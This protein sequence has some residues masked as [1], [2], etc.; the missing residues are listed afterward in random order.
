MGY[1]VWDFVQYLVLPFTSTVPFTL[2]STQSFG[3]LL[4]LLAKNSVLPADIL[5]HQFLQ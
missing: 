3:W 2:A 4:S 1:G 5:L